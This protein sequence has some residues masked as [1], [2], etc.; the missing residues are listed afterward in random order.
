MDV[1]KIAYSRSPIHKTQCPCAEYPDGSS[2]KYWAP[3]PY[4][5]RTFSPV[6]AP[7]LKW[8]EPEESEK[9]NTPF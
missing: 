7:L 3:L 5:E 9:V 1:L 6:D 4:E 2:K 8:A